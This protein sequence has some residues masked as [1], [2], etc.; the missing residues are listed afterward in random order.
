MAVE[1]SERYCPI[2]GKPVTDPTYNRFG[3][4]CCSEAHAEQY[5]KEVRAQKLQAAAALQ[6]Q[7]VAPVDGEEERQQGRAGRRRGGCC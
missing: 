1:T 2:C 5:V 7:P 6:G 3:E 4:L